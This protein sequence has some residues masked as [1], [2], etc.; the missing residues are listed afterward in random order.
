MTEM[1]D[2]EN[3]N[4]LGAS[5]AMNAVS[6]MPAPLDRGCIF[7]HRHREGEERMQI[8]DFPK[9]SHTSELCNAMQL[10]LFISFNVNML[11]CIFFFK[12]VIV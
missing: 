6:Q 8:Y 4:L 9:T 7:L 11:L 12:F 10:K 1:R 2:L 3:G 5:C